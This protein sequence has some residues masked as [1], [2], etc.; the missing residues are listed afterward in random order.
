MKKSPVRSHAVIWMA[1]KSHIAMESVAWLL[2]FNLL[3]L[4]PA[5]PAD[6]R[7]SLQ[8]RIARLE[9]EITGATA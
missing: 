4:S 6:R 1:G 8:A 2:A 5:L 7:T 9:T 3:A